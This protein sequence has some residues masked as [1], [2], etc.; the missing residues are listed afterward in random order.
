M[1]KLREYQQ[2]AI[3]AIRVHY[4]NKVKRVLL[5]L[6]TGAGKTV[7]FCYVFK[8]TLE[9]KPENKALLVVFG[10]SLVEQASK[11]LDEW[12]IDHG[13]IM[14]SHWRNKPQARLQVCSVSTLVSRLNRGKQL[15]GA[16]L[17]VIDEAHNATS[18][19]YKKI[20]DHYSE[21]HFLA[22]TATPHTP[23]G[24]RHVADEVVR[25]ID[26]NELVA[27]GSL[28]VPRYYCP[29]KIDLTGVKT[30]NGDYVEH[31][32]E[33]ALDKSAIFGDLVRNYKEKLDG[34]P[35][36]LFAVSIKHSERIVEDFK[37]AG[38]KAVLATADTKIPE[39]DAIIEGLK[40]GSINV[41]VNVGI[42][43]TGVD[44][45][46]LAGVIL[47]RPTKSYNLYVQQVGRGSRPHPGK[48]N[49]IVLDH[50]GN[51]LE[52]GR[53]E[54]EPECNLDGKPKNKSEEKPTSC[55]SCYAVFCPRENF[56][57]TPIEKIPDHLLARSKISKRLY[58][59]PECGADNTPEGAPII[60]NEGQEDDELVELDGATI[61]ILKIRS[62]FRNWLNIR[63][64]TRNKA[65]KPYHKNFFIYNTLMKAYDYEQLIK[66]L[67]KEMRSIDYA[68]KRSARGTSVSDP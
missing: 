54:D 53:V 12:G 25:T 39:R 3:D 43:C 28:V 29:T 36:I 23:K 16:N 57:N 67:P 34:K 27:Q 62:E 61:T 44:I 52:H 48:E 51:V 21:A 46:C 50:V 37:Q 47:A 10:Q 31:D 38:I 45:P 7:C 49:F 30:R 5:H 55:L 22:V 14:A 42:F 60:K 40:N 56:A 11:R 58:I 63:E 41:V 68:K 64:K 35:A 1:I 20:I 26:F 65:G 6:S 4:L 9:K 2:K 59:C 8:T 33:E 13:V 17:V 19:G 24:L 18:A 66:A 15:P 32:L